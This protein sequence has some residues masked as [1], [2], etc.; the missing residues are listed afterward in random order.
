M[1]TFPNLRRGLERR[2]AVV[3]LGY[4]GLPVAVA[5]ARAGAATIGFDIDQARI[6]ELV[7]L[8]DRTHE[9]TSGELGE[10]AIHFTS[11]KEDLAGSDF[12]IVTVPTPVD[13]A[14]RPDMSIVLAAS[15][16]VASAIRPGAIIVYESTVYPGATEE[17]CVPDAFSSTGTHSSSVAPG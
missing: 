6:S 17:E 11:A 12:F 5:F 1:S 7:A 10:A 16:T 9:I 14:R 2:I 8:H 15:R 13:A 4:V 3:G